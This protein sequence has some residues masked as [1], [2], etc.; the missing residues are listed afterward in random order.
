MCGGNQVVF[1][2]S[3]AADTSE[4]IVTLLSGRK[5]TG[6]AL[7]SNVG[8]TVTLQNDPG[9]GFK[10]H[11]LSSSGPNRVLSELRVIAVGQLNSATVT[12]EG[13]SGS[14]NHPI[15]IFPVGKD[16]HS[17][18]GFLFCCGQVNHCGKLS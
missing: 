16:I 2:C 14:F 18:T 3:Q 4:W 8:R 15:P 17:K 9:F 6:S 7:S 5:L 12:C 10:I 11:V 13:I 1:S